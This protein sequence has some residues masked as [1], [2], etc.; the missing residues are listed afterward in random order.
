MRF[1]TIAT[2]LTAALC[3]CFAVWFGLNRKQAHTAA[4]VDEL[5]FMRAVY[6]LQHIDANAAAEKIGIIPAITRDDATNG[7]LHHTDKVFVLQHLAQELE[8]CT[9]AVPQAAL[10]AAYARLALGQQVEAARLLNNY[11]AE[12]PYD[13]NHYALLCEALSGTGDYALLY[14]T[15]LEWAERAENC[16]KDRALFLWRALMHLERQEEAAEMALQASPCLG[17]EAQVY[18]ARALLGAGKQPQALALI[19]SAAKAAPAERDKIY[20]LWSR[21]QNSSV[22]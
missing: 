14:M 8:A 6:V 15:C 21:L 18:A 1:R 4:M 2:G 7:L 22:F 17:S 19:E 12:A 20:L 3:I 5:R 10:F 16:R 9:P 11:V 13:P